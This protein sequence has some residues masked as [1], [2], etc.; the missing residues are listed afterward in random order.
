MKK[1][2]I[3]LLVC[4]WLMI[5]LHSE[6]VPP[7][8]G[9]TQ[10]F[11]VLGQG[12]FVGYYPIT[13]TCQKIGDTYYLFT[14]DVRVNDIAI[15][16]TDP[17]HLLISTSSGVYVSYDAGATWRF[18]SGTTSGDDAL[19][20]DNNGANYAEGDI[21]IVHRAPI[22]S[23]FYMKEGEWWV[24]YE[25]GA[26]QS[27]D[28][29]ESWTIKTRGLPNYIDPVDEVSVYPPF[30]YMSWDDAVADF[31]GNKYYWACSQAGIFY[32]SKSKYIDMGVGLPQT[33]SDWNHLAVYDFVKTDSLMYIASELG[34]YTG[35]VNMDDE[36]VSWVPIEGADVTVSSS[37]YDT[38]TS[39]I[40]L[41]VDGVELNTYVNIVDAAKSL[42]WRGRVQKS[43]DDL[44]V[45]IQED[46]LYYSD[47]AV[48]DPSSLD[49]STYDAGAVTVYQPSNISISKLQMA[50]DGTLYYVAGTEI[51]KMNS[52]YSTELVYD[53]ATDIND[54]VYHSDKMYIAT[55]NGLFSAGMSDLTD[56]T[57]ETGMLLEG[58][59]NGDTTNYDVRTIEFDSGGNMYIGC[60]MGGLIRKEAASG[61]WT[62]LNIGLGHRAVVPEKT[63]YLAKA[64]DS[65]NVQTSLAPWFGDVPDVDGDARHYCLVVDIDDFYYLDAGDGT[66]YID[67]FFDPTD[68]LSK[69][70]NSNS[71]EM[72]IIYIDSN[73]LELLST[74]ALAAVV[75]AMTVEIIQ[76]KSVPE[77][78]WV[79]RGLGELGE[80]ILGLK[81]T[82]SAYS[83]ANNNSLI[84]IDDISP[85]VK[86]YDYCFT[87][88]DYLYCH[89]FDE[90]SKMLDYVSL[91]ETGL[92]GLN[93]A[94]LNIGGP[95]V[96]ELFNDFT[97]AIYFDGLTYTTIPEKYTF[98]NLV[99]TNSSSQLVWGFGDL[100]YTPFPYVRKQTAW[101]FYVFKTIGMEGGFSK[102]P[103]FSKTVVFNGEDEASFD[104]KTVLKNAA[105]YTEEDLA[106]DARNVGIKDV[107]SQFGDTTSDYQELYFIV[108]AHETPDVSGTA[109]TIFDQTY[110][111]DE[112][113]IGF[114]HNPGAPDYLNLFCFTDNQMYDDAGKARL[115]DSDGNGTADLEGPIGNLIVDGDTTDLT[116]A[117]FYVDAGNSNYIYSTIIDINSIAESGSN[118]AINLEAE[119]INAI[120]STASATGTIAKVT[121]A[122]D[123]TLMVGKEAR[124]TF[125]EGAVKTAHNV[126]AFSTSGNLAKQMSSDVETGAVLSDI[127][128]VSEGINPD[129]PV[130]IKMQLRENPEE[131]GDMVPIL[132]RAKEGQLTAVASA[133]N[134]VNGQIIFETDELGSFQVILAKKEALTETV[135]LVPDK[136]ALQQ[137]FPNP[138]NSSTSIRY[139]LP[140]TSDVR[141]LI[142]DM[143]GRQIKTLYQGQQNAGYYTVKWNG[144]SDDNRLLPSG[145]YFYRL[146][147]SDFQATEKMIY[148]K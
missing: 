127:L 78:E 111:A 135:N 51:Y 3:L 76:T 139:Q 48:F 66:S 98:P 124:V 131:Y 14:E 40:V 8:E 20:V 38:L 89:Y 42:Y 24:G 12:F 133:E 36:M 141:L 37:S 31:D 115:Y 26:F 72:D 19:G 47:A 105:G 32:W 101:S 97:A 41:V 119:N 22:T 33:V 63:D 100:S 99:V 91:E 46:E 136:F 25:E 55:V 148:L 59:T 57:K 1:Y 125:A 104:F 113:S 134:A 118:I 5:P 92:E 79:Y 71:N 64:F 128:Y 53:A 80:L 27:K 82:V 117:Q 103:Y 116:L 132:F 122:G 50:D 138:F 88:F 49:Y 93:T 54:M 130:R 109:F 68:Q 102:S 108:T 62:N 67:G 107:S 16:P 106:L 15:S 86:D 95:T 28:D 44:V 84:T 29:G 45:S 129:K 121:A 58:S 2:T 39:A 23:A 61:E 120:G 126:A 147:S 60:H 13:A 96:E 7:T 110:A 90:A 35:I 144:R 137:N 21:N 30:Y 11:N 123:Q 9:H 114:N 94:L 145:V 74:D 18:A 65:L 112:F 43:G 142:Y 81:D 73:P 77:D 17:N 10:V 69:T 85:T 75:N 6:I 87:L 140:R 52:D 83:L 146:V 56:W 34:L 143:M 70:E 4:I